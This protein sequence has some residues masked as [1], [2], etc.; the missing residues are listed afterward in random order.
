[1]AQV[2]GVAEAH[3]SA[4]RINSVLAPLLAPLWSWRVGTARSDVLDRARRAL[5]QLQAVDDHRVPAMLSVPQWSGC[6]R[7]HHDIRRVPIAP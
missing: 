5:H 4:S 7:S 2:A 6:P 3:P 1:M